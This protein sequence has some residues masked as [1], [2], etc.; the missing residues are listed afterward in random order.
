MRLLV[1]LLCVLAL[2]TGSISAGWARGQAPAA[3]E[4]ILCLGGG[5]VA[6]PV[7]AEGRPTGPAHPCPDGVLALLSPIG[8]TALAERPAA[9]IRPAAATPGPRIPPLS[10][11]FVRPPGRGPPAS[12]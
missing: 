2:L 5:L 9:P 1:P 10:A 4:A 3:G 11:P 12:A 8:P 6:V 7:D